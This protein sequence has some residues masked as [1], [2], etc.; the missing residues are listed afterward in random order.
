MHPLQACWKLKKPVYVLVSA[1]KAW[2][3]RLREVIE[4]YGFEADL[5]DEAIFRLMDSEGGLLGILAIHVDDTLGGG[6]NSFH[7]MMDAVADDLK[8]GARE[9]GTFHYK[10]LWVS[11]IYPHDSKLPFEIAVDGDEY[12]D[13]ALPMPL[14]AGLGDDDR[15]A[16]VD[17]TNYLSVVGCIGSFCASLMLPCTTG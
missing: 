14:P 7:K 17:A 2:F 1:P 5:S 12:L 16:P 4:S 3:D 8:V 10:G 9:R 13:S 6:A 15:L 11:T